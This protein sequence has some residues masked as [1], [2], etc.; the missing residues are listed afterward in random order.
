MKPAAIGWRFYA[1]M[2]GQLVS[3]LGDQIVQLAAALLIV[4]LTGSAFQTGLLTTFAMLP[5]LLFSLPAGTVADRVDRRRL[6]IGCD[7]ARAA[8]IALVPLLASRGALDVWHLYVLAFT[9]TAI[10]AFFDSAALAFLPA[11]AGDERR[12][13]AA[14]GQLYFAQAGLSLLGPAIAGAV[15]A[16]VGLVESFL[17]NSGAYVFSTLALAVIGFGGRFRPT[18]RPATERSSFWSDLVAGLRY[19]LERDVLRTIGV[20]MFLSNFAAMATFAV[21]L[22]HANAVMGL[23]ATQIGLVFSVGGAGGVASALVANRLGERFGHGRVA[24]LGNVVEAAGIAMY[25]VAPDISTLAAASVLTGASP[26]LVNVN[27]F[28]IRYKTVPGELLGR[29][30]AVARFLAWSANP[31]GAFLGGVAAERFGTPPVFAASAVLVL[32]AASGANE[33]GGPQ[34]S[35]RREVLDRIAGHAGAGAVHERVEGAVREGVHDDA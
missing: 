6:M 10:N 30:F 33:L 34:A 27:T 19:V 23:S 5:N 17:A 8:L 26:A 14:N 21:F 32:V 15:V 12:A 18:S 29:V 2:A 9:L 22:F 25:A 11:L 24:V 20:M 16:A 1:Y 3:N 4:R 13:A 31:L 28:A 35:L 7:F